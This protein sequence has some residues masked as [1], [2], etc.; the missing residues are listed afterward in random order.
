MLEGL[1]RSDA[2]N[3]EVDSLQILTFKP[4]DSEIRMFRQVV[5]SKEGREELDLVWHSINT[6]DAAVVGV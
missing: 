5:L 1:L 3:T 6:V 4:H 2:S